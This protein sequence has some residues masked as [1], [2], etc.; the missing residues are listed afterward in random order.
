MWALAPLNL[1][2][3]CWGLT[4][5]GAGITL[6]NLS[7]FDI[8][9]T[10]M[11]REQLHLSAF[12]MTGAVWLIIAGLAYVVGDLAA[13]TSR[14]QRGSPMPRHNSERVA[15][16]T[17]AVNGVLLGVTGIWVISAAAQVGGLLH[18]AIAAYA[19]SL[20]TRDLLLE[21]KLFTGMRLFY[22]ALPATGCLAAA[23]LTSHNLTT[24][25]RRLMQA[26][27][28]L[29]TT[30]LFL[31]PIIMSQRLLLLQ[32][33]LSSYLVAC[34]MRRR[35]VG[36]GWLALAVGLFLSLWVAREAITNPSFARSATDIGLQKLAFYLVND[37][38]NSFAP[39]TIPIPHTYGGVLMEGLMFFTFTDGYFMDLLAPRFAVLDTLRGGGE[40][41][42]L[43]AAYVDFGPVFGSVF[44]LVTGFVMRWI[45]SKTN[46]SLTWSAIYA[47]LGAALLFSSHAV[48]FTHQN[49]L[50]SLLV[51]SGIM[52]ASRRQSSIVPESHYC[53]F[54][55]SLDG[56][57][58]Q[59][60]LPQPPNS[61]LPSRAK[62]QSTGSALHK[63]SARE[64]ADA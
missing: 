60:K 16:L 28:I 58:S 55:C 52:F 18:L 50:C 35:V 3:L 17:F 19:D 2:L 56:Y 39:L 47:Q 53:I 44:I 45:F 5:I 33:V 14:V 57:E 38:W 21:N 25:G 22:A 41:P 34:L 15:H 13:R 30:S 29:N 40:F 24:S 6:S 12:S 42:L 49:F 4:A 11:T 27:L 8:V 7:S 36:L 9:Q 61:I 51:I 10:I 31:L 32:L 46:G 1:V 63:G 23:L 54:E 59:Q 62:I 64:S 37:M 43:T 26:T 20:V 48:Y